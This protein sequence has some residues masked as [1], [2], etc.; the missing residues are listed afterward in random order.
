MGG[1]PNA[2]AIAETASI[3]GW[4]AF[5]ACSQ[6]TP[7]HANKRPSRHRFQLA[8][9]HNPLKTLLSLSQQATFQS[10]DAAASLSIPPATKAGF[11]LKA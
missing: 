1:S 11:L 7:N 5:L 3:L 10:G 6:S 8:E 2:K 9:M 4:V